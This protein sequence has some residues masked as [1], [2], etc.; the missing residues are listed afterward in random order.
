MPHV[1][2]PRLPWKRGAK[3]PCR[4]RAP[5]RRSQGSCQGAG[6]SPFRVL[7]AECTTDHC[8]EPMPLPDV[9]PRG[10]EGPNTRNQSPSSKTLVA[11]ADLPALTRCEIKGSALPDDVSSLGGSIATRETSCP[12]KFHRGRPASKSR[13]AERTEVSMT[14]SVA[15]ISAHSLAHCSSG[16]PN[17]L[18]VRPQLALNTSPSDL[19]PLSGKLGLAL[20]FERRRPSRHQVLGHR[21]RH[22]AFVRVVAQPSQD[23]LADERTHHCHHSVLRSPTIAEFRNIC[24]T[25]NT[26]TCLRTSPS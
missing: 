4:S 25:P 14:H 9:G 5:E 12:K 16:R 24:A 1:S 17:A 15:L 23:H 10:S 20:V 7:R 26:K 18:V 2:N 8:P 19:I 3:I 6:L 22:H 13:V 21:Y 11:D